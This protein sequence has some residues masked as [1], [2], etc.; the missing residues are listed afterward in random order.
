MK[1]AIIIYRIFFAFVCGLGL[2][3]GMIN[4]AEDGFMG[5]GTALNFY[6]L[7]SNL[8]V[9]IL[10]CF[11]ITFSIIEERKHVTIIGSKVVV[12]KFVLTVAIL[13]T[14]IVYWCMLAP[15]IN[16]NDIF[17]LSNILL[18]LVS[19]MLMLVDFLFLDRDFSFGKENIF[20]VL[21][22]P[23]YYL[24]FAICRAEVSS[25]LFNNGSRY[26]YWFVDLDTFGWLGSINGPGVIYWALLLFVG[27]FFLGTAIY[28]MYNYIGKR[29]IF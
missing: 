5:N 14:F 24:I 7:Q 2:Y 10:E 23:L 11:L 3:L 18:H 4:K 29:R 6:T 27:V 12:V 16:Q 19:P 28:K 22:P 25:T 8:W 9:F 21:I 17:A 1:K 20:L 15:Y 13:I 26:P